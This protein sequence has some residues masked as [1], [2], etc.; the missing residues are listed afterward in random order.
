MSSPQDEHL[1][2][3]NIHND[4]L[5]QDSNVWEYIAILL[6]GKLTI[7]LTTA[8]V[9]G[10]VIIYN[11]KTKPVYEATSLVL[12]D[13]KGKNGTLPIFDMTG[14]A[15]ANNITN[16]IEILKS[17]SVAEDVANALLS[18]KFLDDEGTN[19]NPNFDSE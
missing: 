7:L 11:N 6:R 15:N 12:I 1:K 13:M 16:E 2:T 9:V 4:A 8:L 19:I 17:A 14:T 18:K 5:S 10:L 3:K